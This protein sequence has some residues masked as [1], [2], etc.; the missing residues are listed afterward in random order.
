MNSNKIFPTESKVLSAADYWSSLYLDLPQKVLVV[1]DSHQ[2]QSAET[3]V[4]LDVLSLMLR[5]QTSL[6]AEPNAHVK[7]KAKEA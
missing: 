7:M 3:E 4:T 6:T 1:E 5:R 2:K